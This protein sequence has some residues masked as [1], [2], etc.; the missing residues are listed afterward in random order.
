MNYPFWLRHKVHNIFSWTLSQYRACGFVL[1]RISDI[2]NISKIFMLPCVLT[3]NVGFYRIR[4]WHWA[5]I[6]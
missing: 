3:L 1:M 4:D 2:N 5:F 6:W